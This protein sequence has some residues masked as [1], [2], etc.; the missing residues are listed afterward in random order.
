MPQSFFGRWLVVWPWLCAAGCASFNPSLR[1]NELS[2]TRAPTVAETRQAL[3]VSV[4]EFVSPSNSRRAFDS[5]TAAYGVLSL[6]LR[7]ENNSTVSRKLLRDQVRVTLGDELLPRM[8][9]DDAARQAALKSHGGNALAWTLATGPFALLLAPITLT[10]SSA[11]TESVNRRIEQ[12]FG[13]MELPDLLLRPNESAAGFVFYGLPFD[14]NRLENLAVGITVIDESSGEN[15]PFE[16]KLPT[17][18]IALHPSRVS[19]SR[20]QERE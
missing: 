3:R 11:H 4:E 20:N 16:F 19:R 7:I 9:A 17:F 1:H 18:E 13:T 10:G 5:D 2:A 8:Q 15:I 14:V 6:L 12:H